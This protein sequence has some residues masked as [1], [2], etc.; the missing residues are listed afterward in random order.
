[1]LGWQGDAMITYM[2]NYYLFACKALRICLILKVVGAPVVP[3]QL[4][5]KNINL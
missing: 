4:P 2:A 1:M 3:Q 5:I